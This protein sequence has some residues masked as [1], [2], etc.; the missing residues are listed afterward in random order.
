VLRFI[1]TLLS[2]LTAN[3][4]EKI[5]AIQPVGPPASTIGEF[6][7]FQEEAAEGETIRD[8]LAQRDGSDIK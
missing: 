8:V 4:Q 5:M 3:L 6:H 2:I 7:T 1:T